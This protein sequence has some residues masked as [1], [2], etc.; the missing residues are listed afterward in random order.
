MINY[1]HKKIS[2][3]LNSSSKILY[4]G[5]T[6]KEN[7]PDFR[8]SKTT[9]IYSILNSKKMNLTIVDPYLSLEIKNK[10]GMTYSDV[11]DEQMTELEEFIK[12]VCDNPR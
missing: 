6:F 11:P 4:L 10:F 9:E 3:Y 5:V 1:Y 12:Y 7:C 8:N 2:K